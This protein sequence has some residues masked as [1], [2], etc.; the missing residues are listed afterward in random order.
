MSSSWDK[1]K[2]EE[3]GDKLTFDTI[4]HYAYDALN[5]PSSEGEEFDMEMTE[6]KVFSPSTK[7]HFDVPLKGTLAHRHLLGQRLLNYALTA[8]GRTPSGD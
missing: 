6:L 1:R 8:G 7:Y 3:I 2:K 5:I 4:L